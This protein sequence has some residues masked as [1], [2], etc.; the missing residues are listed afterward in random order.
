MNSTRYLSL[1]MTLLM[2]FAIPVFAGDGT[3]QNIP[4]G[5][6]PQAGQSVTIN[7]IEMYYETYGSGDPLLL[8]HG[9]GHS[10]ANLNY[11]IE[12][13]SKNYFVIV[14]DN[15]GHGKSGMGE[16]PL[17]YIQMMEDYNALLEK[18]GVSDARVFGWSDGGILALLL[19][20][21]HPDKV[22]KMAVMGA[23]L[24][25]G[26]TAVY[27]WVPELLQ[28]LSDM[29]DEM[30]ASNDTSD[31]WQH[32]RQLLNLLMTQPDIS[33]ESLQAIKAP[34]L[35]IASDKD[36]IR[37]RHTME[38]F[39]NL[40]NAHMAVLPG[41]THW[42]PATDPVGFNALLE[43]F[44]ATPYSRP[45]SQEVLTAELNPPQS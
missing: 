28:P 13:F 29:V 31:D 14:G 42:A 37:T 8:I 19:A 1:I 20:I 23:N 3:P 34:V 43:K 5:D 4:Y 35:V 40:P 41:Q 16:G 39:E 6:N 26:Q 22:S 2:M 27:E 21:N 10:I 44:F 45:T 12:Q 18:L 25:P 9:N 30:I 7:D 15:R 11:Q 24:R 32:H 33:H 36:I 17:N 38:I